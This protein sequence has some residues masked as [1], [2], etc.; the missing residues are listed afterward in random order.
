MRCGGSTR[1]RIAKQPSSIKVGGG[2]L[3]ARDC[4]GLAFRRFLYQLLQLRHHREQHRDHDDPH[5]WG[6]HGHHSTDHLS[7]A[8]LPHWKD[9]LAPIL[10]GLCSLRLEEKVVEDEDAVLSHPGSLDKRG[11]RFGRTCR[12]PSLEQSSQETR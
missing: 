1:A 10:L 12:P 11:E 7:F 8:L 9:L 3:W 5:R 2:R 4:E 6:W